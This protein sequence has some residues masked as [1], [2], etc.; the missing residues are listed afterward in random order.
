MFDVV[1]DTGSSDLWVASDACTEG[2]GDPA[3]LYPQAGFKSAGI[4]IQLNYGDSFT[5]TFASGLIGY[6][7]V[8][9]DGISDSSQAFAAIN[10]TSLQQVEFGIPG[11][12]GVGFPINRC[13]GG[14]SH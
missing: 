10:R 1:V 11:I 3:K 14:P 2:C 13:V 12:L 8:S 5:G 6:D 4:D 9:L 7:N